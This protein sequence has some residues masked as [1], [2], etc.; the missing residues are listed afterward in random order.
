MEEL[1]VLAIHLD[2]EGAPDKVSLSRACHSFERPNSASPTILLTTCWSPGITLCWGA[3]SLSSAVCPTD[4][5]LAIFCIHK[6]TCTNPSTITHSTSNH[7]QRPGRPPNSRV[8]SC[9]ERATTFPTV[10]CSRIES[11][12]CSGYLAHVQ[13][14]MYSRLM[15]PWQ[16]RVPNHRV[17]CCLCAAP[18]IRR[19]LRRSS[20]A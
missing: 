19:K 18:H 14:N 12:R 16:S 11:H 5:S 13:R 9:T 17:L 7:M 2:V 1:A 6:L 3:P 8:N 10:Y 4:I 20:K 15:I